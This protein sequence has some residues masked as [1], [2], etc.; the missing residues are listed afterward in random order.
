MPV[1]EEKKVKLPCLF[2]S[3]LNETEKLDNNEQNPD[4]IS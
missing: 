1:Q 2:D 4:G 3:F